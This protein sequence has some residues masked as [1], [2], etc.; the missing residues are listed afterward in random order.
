LRGPWFTGGDGELRLH[1]V[2]SLPVLLVTLSVD[3]RPGLVELDKGSLRPSNDDLVERSIGEAR[4]KHP[5]PSSS[6]TLCTDF[7]L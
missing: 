1:P 2:S 7:F 4:A 3:V 5:S 6:S